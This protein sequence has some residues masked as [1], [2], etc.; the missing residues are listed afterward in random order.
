MA[1][2]LLMVSQ[3]NLTQLQK[4]FTILW[5]PQA[6]GY[7]PSSIAS[8][9]NAPWWRTITR[10]PKGLINGLLTTEQKTIAATVLLCEA[11]GA[12]GVVAL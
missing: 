3:G 7:V 10:L 2:M 11:A 1:A 8:C 12:L 4:A 5:M 9:N 6:G